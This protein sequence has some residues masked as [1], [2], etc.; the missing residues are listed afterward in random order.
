MSRRT[1]VLIVAVAL[2]G[3]T[4][5][6][7]QTPP[8]MPAPA[9]GLAVSRPHTGWLTLQVSGPPGAVAT[10]SES[11]SHRPRAGRHGDA[12]ARGLGRHRTGGPVAL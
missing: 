5:A 3:D 9:V 10:V 2:A 11:G 12:G 1:V 4:S 7:A 6:A 8:V